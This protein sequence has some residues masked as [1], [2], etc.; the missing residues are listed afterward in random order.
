M[1]KKMVAILILMMA[2]PF[3]ASAEDPTTARIVTYKSNPVKC[4]APIVVSVV[5]GRLRQL[6]EMGFKIEPGE[7]SLHGRATVD[8]RNCQPIETNSRKPVNVP[9]LD[10]FFEPG[11]VYYVGLDYSPRNREDWR[12]VVWK[13]EYEDGELVFDKTK[14]ET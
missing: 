8:L 4:I 3:A 2:F 13:V 9:P 14:P 10:W 7:H 12:I 5:D 11:K 6:P 1:M